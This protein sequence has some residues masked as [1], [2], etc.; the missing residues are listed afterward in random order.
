MGRIFTSVYPNAPPAR[1]LVTARIFTYMHPNTHAELIPEVMAPQTKYIQKKS[2]ET[3][4]TSLQTPFQF[5]CPQ[6]FSS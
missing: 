5:I 1:V 4:T 3:S 6:E 2:F